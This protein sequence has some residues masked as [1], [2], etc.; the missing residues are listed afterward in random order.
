MATG[1]KKAVPVGKYHFFTDEEVSGLD[2][3]LC[4]MIDM[5]RGKAGIPFVITSGLRSFADNQ[6]LCE[7]VSD[8]SHLTGHG[9][10][11]A[12]SDSESRYKMLT[13]CLASGFNRIGVYASHIHVDNDATKPPNVVWYVQGS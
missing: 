2:T 9:V 1:Y 4:A 3:E 11:L 12:C 10:D 5:A 13:A 7:S 8:S 6:G